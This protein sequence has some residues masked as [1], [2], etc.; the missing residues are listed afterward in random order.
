MS[1]DTENQAI[2]TEGND[3]SID[4]ATQQFLSLDDDGEQP[5]PKNRENDE[6]SEQSDYDEE[7]RV[8]RAADDNAQVEILGEVRTAKEW[9][10]GFL[11]QDDY[12]RKTQEVS[13]YRQEMA[14]QQK[15]L[16][17]ERAKYATEL[18]LITRQAQQELKK[19]ENVDWRYMAQVNP[20]D[21][22]KYKEE[23]NQAQLTVQQLEAQA[24]GLFQSVYEKEQAEIQEKAQHCV[25]VLSEV[26]E[27]W[28]D[29]AY[30]DLVEYGTSM[31]M[32]QNFLLNATD[33]GVFVMLF[34]AQSADSERNFKQKINQSNQG[35]RNK[36]I[37]MSG[38]GKMV[39]GG[40]K[41]TQ[42]RQKFQKSGSIEDATS[43]FE[44]LI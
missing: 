20:A 17:T 8:L 10:E 40:N 29:E 13:Q 9:R 5:N 4:E 27:N 22:V 44:D 15:A 6:E 41:Q 14:Q 2:E 26:F 24:E 37:T 12:T 35:S 23:F 1:N 31:G 11:R 19:F 30:Y 39:G 16:E 21:Y 43:V 7:M 18:G 34:K 42:A 38:T 3:A 28:S 33:P 36:G 25:T 32:D